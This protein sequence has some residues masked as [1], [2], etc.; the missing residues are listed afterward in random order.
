MEKSDDASN[1]TGV[2]EEMEVDDG[3]M[4]GIDKE[5]KEG[6]SIEEEQE[7]VRKKALAQK[8]YRTIVKTILPHLQEVLTKKVMK[9]LIMLY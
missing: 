5:E 3:M 4:V 8:I 1:E 7:E 9:I 6:S 2:A